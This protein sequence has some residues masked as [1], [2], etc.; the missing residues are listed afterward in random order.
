MVLRAVGNCAE[1]MTNSQAEHRLAAYRDGSCQPRRKA[2]HDLD[3]PPDSAGCCHPCRDGH[4]R[5][6]GPGLLLLGFTGHQHGG[7]TCDL[8]RVRAE[9]HECRHR[10]DRDHGHSRG[11]RHNLRRPRHGGHSADLGEFKAFSATCTHQG[12]KVTRIESGVIMCPCHNSE[13][14][15]T[16]GA[17][18]SGPAKQ[19]LATKTVT[20]SGDSLTVA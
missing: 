5:D 12:C 7:L 3:R 14:D 15:I 19:A 6:R 10:R 2:H 1:A 17:V 16:T 4:L 13:F 20:V 18:T 8:G 11:R 9:R